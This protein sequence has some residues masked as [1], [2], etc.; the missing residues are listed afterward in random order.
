MSEQDDT[1]PEDERARIER[2]RRMPVWERVQEWN[3]VTQAHRDHI[4][5]DIREQ[6]PHADEQELRKRFAA[7]TLPREIVIKMFDWDP[8]KEGY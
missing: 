4:L 2:I 7:R 1:G 5:A 3:A 6:Y 8:E